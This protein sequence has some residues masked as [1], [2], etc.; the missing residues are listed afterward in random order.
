[1]EN[2]EKL[3]KK[4]LNGSITSSELDELLS[5][6]DLQDFRNLIKRIFDL[7][8]GT[9]TNN[10]SASK[11]IL[12]FLNKISSKRKIRNIRKKLNRPG[13]RDDKKL[14]IA[15]GDSWFEYPVFIKDI[16]DWIIKDTDNPV[17]SLA[18]GGDWISNIIYEEQYIPE[19]SMYQPEVFLISGGGNDLVG[20]GR[21]SVLVNKPSLVD[22]SETEEDVKLKE[23][24][25]SQNFDNGEINAVQRADMI[26]RGTKYL[27]NDFYGL[28]KTFEI[29]Y[30]LFFKRIELSKKFDDMKIITQGYDFVIPSNNKTIFKNPLKWVTNNGKWLYYPLVRKGISDKYEQQSIL[31]AMIYYF[32][33]M[34]ISVG[35]YCNKNKGTN[36]VFHIDSRGALKEKEWSDELHPTSKSFRKISNVYIKCINEIASFDSENPNIYPVRKYI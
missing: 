9:I 13:F 4:L 36:Y 1:M 18:Y 20:D 12:G 26:V 10:S 24:I 5:L 32:N 27:N 29:M 28:M 7:N 21:L 19:L 22:F 17:Y 15:E 11:G 30:K 35:E 23:K 33:E 6:I 3:I 14:I 16:I 8:E 34:L 25:I 2:K 31:S